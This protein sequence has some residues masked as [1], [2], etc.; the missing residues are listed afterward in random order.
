MPLSVCKYA[1]AQTAQDNDTQSVRGTRRVRGNA[2]RE[3]LRDLKSVCCLL[4]PLLVYC[5]LFRPSRL[6][7][8]TTVAT[9]EPNSCRAADCQCRIIIIKTRVI[10]FTFLTRAHTRLRIIRARI[11]YTG[12]R[13]VVG[14]NH[15]LPGGIAHQGNPE[16]TPVRF[17]IEMLM[18]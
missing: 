1:N 15:S 2:E 9:A 4:R 14:I 10:I 3:R 16:T 18:V 8:C 13:R 5:C 7:G 17:A 11:V 12:L 6:I